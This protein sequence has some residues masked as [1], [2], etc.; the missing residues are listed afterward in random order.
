MTEEEWPHCQTPATMI[1]ALRRQVAPSYYL[2]AAW[3]RTLRLFACAGA[4]R[5]LSSLAGT[6]EALSDPRAYM[7]LDTAER[8]AENRATAAELEQARR[9]ATEVR[10][11]TYGYGLARWLAAGEIVD[12]CMTS[13]RADAYWRMVGLAVQGRDSE[14]RRALA[15]LV[16][17]FFPSLHPSSSVAVIPSKTVRDLAEALESGAEVAF[18]LHDA[19]L[20]SG[21]AALAD[22]FRV[23]NHPRGCWAL[24][25]ILEKR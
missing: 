5:R 8:F 18:A 6:A 23:A 2:D 12:V 17:H 13:P 11:G 19:L 16:R 21:H 7:A 24:D 1:E 25:R 3:A 22:H 9:R 10:D 14:D 4:R 20:E 15:D